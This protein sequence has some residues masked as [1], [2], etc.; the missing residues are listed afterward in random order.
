MKLFWGV[1]QAADLSVS[2]V[3]LICSWGWQL[4]P[5]TPVMISSGWK[6]GLTFSRDLSFQRNEIEVGKW[7]LVSL[8][9]HFVQPSQ[10]SGKVL[11]ANISSRSP[12]SSPCLWVCAIL[13]SIIMAKGIENTNEPVL[14]QCQERKLHQWSQVDCEWERG[15]FLPER[16]MWVLLLEKRGKETPGGSLVLSLYLLNEWVVELYVFLILSTPKGAQGIV[17]TPQPYLILSSILHR[18]STDSQDVDLWNTISFLSMCLGRL[19]LFSG[20]GVTSTKQIMRTVMWRK[21]YI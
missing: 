13:E 3:I 17:S 12:E 2:Q 6:K 15:S 9:S 1:V 5:K 8:D 20:N 14:G 10:S 11:F 19:F 4:L 18:D 16:N 7:L 21:T